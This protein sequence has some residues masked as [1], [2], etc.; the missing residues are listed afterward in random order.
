MKRSLTFNGLDEM[1]DVLESDLYA[2]LFS[3]DKPD[4]FNID[5]FEKVLDDI[6]QIIVNQTDGLTNL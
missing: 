2:T 1:L 6:H 4:H 3:K 5:Y